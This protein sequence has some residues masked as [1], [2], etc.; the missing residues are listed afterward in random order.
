MTGFKYE[1]FNTFEE[2]CIAEVALKFN[3]CPYPGATDIDKLESELHT[4]VD[5]GV[6]PTDTFSE[7]ITKS[8]L[9]L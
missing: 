6:V 7:D 5:T 8:M 1:Y 4:R 2:T 9:E 3:A